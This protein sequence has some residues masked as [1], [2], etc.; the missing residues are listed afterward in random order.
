MAVQTENVPKVGT[1]FICL[2]PS[3]ERLFQVY[4]MCKEAECGGET[5][6]LIL[7]QTVGG[8]SREIPA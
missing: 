4:Q 6:P 3:R 8:K 1:V 2:T 5:L 7:Q